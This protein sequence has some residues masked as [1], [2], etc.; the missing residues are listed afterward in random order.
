VPDPSAAPPAPPEPHP[1]PA[2]PAHPAPIPPLS[3]ALDEMPDIPEDIETRPDGTPGSLAAYAPKRPNEVY[4]PREA[5]EM[6]ALASRPK[7]WRQ[8]NAPPGHH[9][10]PPPDQVPATPDCPDPGLAQRRGPLDL[11]ENIYGGD[12]LSRFVSGRGDPGTRSP[13]FDD[14]EDSIVELEVISTGGDPESEAYKAALI[15]AHPE[16]K[17]ISVIR[18]GSGAPASIPPAPEDAKPP[19]QE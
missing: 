2:P 4:I 10:E 14:T 9:P 6:I 3:L 7:P 12:A 16:G 8:V 11:T 5:P 18:L 17:P 1:A 15:A 13:L 19:E